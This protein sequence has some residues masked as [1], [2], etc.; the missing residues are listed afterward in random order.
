VR[1]IL[2]VLGEGWDK[3]KS[4]GKGLRGQSSGIPHLA[5]NERDVGHPALVATEK[6]KGQ[7][8]DGASPRLGYPTYAGANVEHPDRV[9]VVQVGESALAVAAASTR[10]S[11][12]TPAA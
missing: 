5:K 7:T 8:F 3:Q 1:T 12:C 11:A 6:R 9:G 10:A 4:A 2:R